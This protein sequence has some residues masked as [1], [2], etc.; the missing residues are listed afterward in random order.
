MPEYSN[1]QEAAEALI[2]RF[3]TLPW[4]YSCYV[5][6]PF[7]A[8]YGEDR[9]SATQL[10]NDLRLFV[11]DDE[12][13][14]K[15]PL[16][17]NEPLLSPL[18]QR[19]VPEQWQRDAYY[20]EANVKG[21]VGRLFSRDALMHVA[22]QLKSLAGFV[23]AL[24]L[25]VIER[26]FVRSWNHTPILAYS[27]EQDPL[28][29]EPH[30]LNDAE[31][32]VMQSLRIGTTN[33][34]P[35]AV[36]S[37]RAALLVTSYAAVPSSILNAARWYFESH[38]SGNDVLAFVQAMVV[39]EILFGDK[40]ISDAVG[41][42]QLLANRLAYAIGRTGGERETLIADFNRLYATRSAI[43]HRG[44]ESLS[45]KERVDLQRL[46]DL[47]ESAIRHELLVVSRGVQP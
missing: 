15:Y 40:S 18:T 32:D 30:W 12:H 3:E 23:I 11:P 37:R 25:G 36:R 43:V 39:L 29:M 7:P 22:N 24:K 8:P 1:A 41:V 27:D 10:T 2:G 21:Y 28:T 17:P 19:S 45:A 33:A 42:G 9:P 16:P 6:T 5:K 4:R 38:C 46:R 31:A 26:S 14:S 47:C 20:L 35:E 34:V 13:A 44:K